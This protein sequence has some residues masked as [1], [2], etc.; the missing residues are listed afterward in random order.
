MV[1]V[2]SHGHIRRRWLALAVITAFS[3]LPRG[4]SAQTI[5]SVGT[6][7]LGMGGAFVAVA[8]DSSATWWNPGALADGLFLDMTLGRAA[9][10]VTEQVPGFRTSVSQFSLTTPPVGFSYYRLRITE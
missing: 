10:G 1:M 9:G 2:R 5:E 7:A 8:N 6:R 4:A 3:V